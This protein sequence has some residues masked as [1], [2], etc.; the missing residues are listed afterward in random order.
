MADQIYGRN[1]TG[2]RLSPPLRQVTHSNFLGSV[3][4]PTRNVEISIQKSRS[5]SIEQEDHANDQSAL[6]QFPTDR[7]APIL[8]SSLT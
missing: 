4:Q 1:F 3:A 5:R 6:W 2:S 8:T 7:I